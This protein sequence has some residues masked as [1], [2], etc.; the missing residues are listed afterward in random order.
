MTDITDDVI[1]VLVRAREHGMRHADC[2][3]LVAD[4]FDTPWTTEKHWSND[5]TE[6]AA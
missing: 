5:T 1:E 4:V 3:A 6:V 2:A